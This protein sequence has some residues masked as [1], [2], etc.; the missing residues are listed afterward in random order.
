MSG[1]LEE[2]TDEAAAGPA[3]AQVAQNLTL[4]WLESQSSSTWPPTQA[5]LMARVRDFCELDVTIAP[6]TVAGVLAQEGAVSVEGG[7]PSPDADEGVLAAQSQAAVRID[8]DAVERL[9][10][11]IARGR[12][13]V[14]SAAVEA[15]A[16]RGLRALMGLRGV[17][18]PATFAELLGVLAPH[19][20]VRFKV[21]PRDVVEDLEL[22]GF[23]DVDDKTEV[24]TYNG[25]K[26]MSFRE[27]PL[28]KGFGWKS[29]VL[30]I[31]IFFMM[32]PNVLTM[33]GVW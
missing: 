12:R 9:V 22:A 28:N 14:R 13:G 30:V 27:P 7:V 3:E 17:Q 25:P 18:E 26:I 32:A 11:A 21:A 8:Y 15:A 31:F 10:A 19:G 20:H 4:Q 29:M 6:I 33:L 5:A 16:E 2:P 1:H 23:L 24:V